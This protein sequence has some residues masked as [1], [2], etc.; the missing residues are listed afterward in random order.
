MTT[1]DIINI[2]GLEII[3]RCMLDDECRDIDFE[4]YISIMDVSSENMVSKVLQLIDSWGLGYASNIARRL[5]DEGYTQA[6]SP[7]QVLD[8][9]KDYMSDTFIVWLSRAKSTQ[10]L[11]EAHA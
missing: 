2:L 9:I 6:I 11:L 10:K 4:K 1:K 3:A 7:L 5:N 8:M